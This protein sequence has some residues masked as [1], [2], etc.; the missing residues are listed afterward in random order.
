M[1]NWKD[2]QIIWTSPPLID[3]RTASREFI[4]EIMDTERQI[5]AYTI[6]DQQLARQLRR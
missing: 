5:L 6:N 2:L 3:G 4:E 1:E